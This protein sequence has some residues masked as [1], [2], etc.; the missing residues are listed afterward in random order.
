MTADTDDDADTAEDQRLDDADRDADLDDL[1]DYPTRA[2]RRSRR[3][4]EDE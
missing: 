3:S 1:G 4:Y 2:P